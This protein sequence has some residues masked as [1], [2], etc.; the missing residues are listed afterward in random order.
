M[1]NTKYTTSTSISARLDVNI[2]I[3]SIDD[4]VARQPCTL[5][6]S[7][8]GDEL[9]MQRNKGGGQTFSRRSEAGLCPPQIL[10]TASRVRYICSRRRM[11]E[12]EEEVM[13]LE[14]TRGQG[15]SLGAA[16]SNRV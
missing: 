3:K 11:E 8:L 2:I 6:H 15:S 1:D 10:C 12:K 7:G 9:A 4:R 5:H 13:V 16:R 14:P